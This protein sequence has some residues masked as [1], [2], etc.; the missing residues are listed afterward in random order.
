MPFLPF[1]SRAKGKRILFIE[2]GTSAIK[3]L[4]SQIKDSQ[5][6]ILEIGI[7]PAEKFLWEKSLQKVI[8]SIRE[9]Y[10]PIHTLILNLSPLVFRAGVFRCS[11][12]RKKAREIV[13][14]KKEEQELKNC[15]IGRE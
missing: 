11:L 2:A 10:P 15:L 7:A 13:I 8:T 9:K 3:F 4:L 12:T 1:D 5:Q 14:Q 6:E